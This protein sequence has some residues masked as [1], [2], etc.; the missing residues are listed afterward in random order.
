LETP[1]NVSH[2][3]DRSRDL[4]SS[5]FGITRTI[6]RLDK[7]STKQLPVAVNDFMH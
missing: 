1:L 5:L 2:R 4:V 3:I 6:K 7:L